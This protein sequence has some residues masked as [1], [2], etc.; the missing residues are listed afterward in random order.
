MPLAHFPHFQRQTCVVAISANR[1]S[2][3]ATTMP[4][5]KNLIGNKSHKNQSIDQ[6]LSIVFV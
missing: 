4:Q 2:T 6:N 3:T 5:V 1:E